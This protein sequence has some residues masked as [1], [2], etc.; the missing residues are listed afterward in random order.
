MPEAVAGPPLEVVE[1]PCGPHCERP[2]ARSLDV[3]E[4][5]EYQQAGLGQPA[6][7]LAEASVAVPEQCRA[8]LLLLLMLVL[9]HA[10]L[11]PRPLVVASEEQQAA[12]APE[13]PRSWPS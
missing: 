4:A 1:Q 6:G 8:A 5:G 3:L 10:K 9:Q 12:R 13:P 7:I 2:G 11:V